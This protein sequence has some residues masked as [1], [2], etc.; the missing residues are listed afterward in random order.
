[1]RV[2]DETGGQKKE[3]KKEKTNEESPFACVEIYLFYEVC[4]AFR[5]PFFL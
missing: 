2:Y 1:M 4:P 5:F 3:K